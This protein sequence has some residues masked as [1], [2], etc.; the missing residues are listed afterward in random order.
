ME[1]LRRMNFELRHYRSMM[2]ALAIG[3]LSC[4]HGYTHLKELEPDEIEMDHYGAVTV[5]SF[6]IV[7]QN[8]TGEEFKMRYTAH[9]S[10]IGKVSLT[11]LSCEPSKVLIFRP[12]RVMLGESEDT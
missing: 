11:I 5:S 7:E 6:S 9:V 1:E 8:N 4:E 12:C 3:C 2:S 10:C